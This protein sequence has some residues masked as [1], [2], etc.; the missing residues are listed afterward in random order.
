MMLHS[1]DA[2]AA[3]AAGRGR[4]GRD[5]RVHDPYA[6]VVAP[7]LSPD[8]RARQAEL[9][10]SV[11][12]S[13]EA[14]APH[15]RRVTEL[16]RSIA[17][18]DGVLCLLGAGNCNDLDLARLLDASGEIHLVDVDTE[19]MARGVERQGL[20][21]S[22]A[23][24]LHPHDV[25]GVMERLAAWSV[26]A[27]P[28]N[29]E[30]DEC[31]FELATTPWIGVE[32]RSVHVAISAGVISQLT[33]IAVRVLGVDHPRSLEVALAIRDAHLRLV[34]SLARPGG[35]GLLVTDLASSE[36]VKDLEHAPA[37][38]LPGVMDEV[39][40][41]GEVHAGTDPLGIEAALREDRR[42]DTGIQSIVRHPP[43][44]WRLGPDKVQ[45]TYGISFRT[46]S[47]GCTAEG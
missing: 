17:P 25:T 22:T 32:P 6:S 24:H 13:W 26:G 16:I 23:L 19:A 1:A 4:S 40:Q 33:G 10:R 18:N 35:W 37:E 9:N 8:P 42:V 28:T 43:W 12:G 39:V 29:A 45:L 38:A 27:A 34:A 5:E 11:A 30:I 14:F 2:P 15:R 46:R 41:S 21:G 20:D 36:T 47:E 31:V 7:A 3:R 44:L